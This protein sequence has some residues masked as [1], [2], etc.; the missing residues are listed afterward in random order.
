MHVDLPNSEERRAFFEKLFLDLTLQ[1]TKVKK[2]S[3][4]KIFQEG[5]L[6]LKDLLSE[7]NYL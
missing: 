1:T 7:F 6:T 4:K 3:K 2:S 5:K